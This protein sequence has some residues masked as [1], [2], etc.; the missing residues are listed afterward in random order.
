MNE[1]FRCKNQVYCPMVTAKD[2]VCPDTRSPKYRKKSERDK[3]VAQAFPWLKLD[4]L[5][6]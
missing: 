6:D 5:H 1:T 3:Q 2:D 4:K